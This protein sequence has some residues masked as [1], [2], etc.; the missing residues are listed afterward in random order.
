MNIDHIAE[1]SK[2]KLSEYEKEKMIDDFGRTID[3]VDGLKEVNV[4]E[5]SPT[6]HVLNIENVYREDQILPSMKQDEVLK[7]AP[8]KNDG[9]FQ[10][11]RMIE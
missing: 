1:L 4:D 5:V 7:N 9:Y 8:K 10:V 6:Y 3:F 11:P 2:I